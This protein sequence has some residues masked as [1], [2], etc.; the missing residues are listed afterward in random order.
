M[1]DGQFDP[2]ADPEQL[3]AAVLRLSGTG[4]PTSAE[5]EDHAQQL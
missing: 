2:G 4:L 1:I 3:V 5:P